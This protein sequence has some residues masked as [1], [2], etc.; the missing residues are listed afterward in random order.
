[1]WE[2]ASQSGLVNDILEQTNVGGGEVL[3]LLMVE[4]TL[5]LPNSEEVGA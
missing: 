2:D 1:M 3:E 4:K 5:I